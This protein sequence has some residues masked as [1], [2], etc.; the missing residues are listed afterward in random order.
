M[1]KN[2][3]TQTAWSVVTFLRVCLLSV[4]SQAQAGGA[5]SSTSGNS[6]ASKTAS[7]PSSAAA[8]SATANA[9][10]NLYGAGGQNGAQPTQDSFKGSIVSG[11]ATDGVLELS[12]NEA[13]QRGLQQNLGLILQTATQKSS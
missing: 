11:K 3:I 13:I 5:T 7:G 9:Q 2:K 12:L 8:S 10:Q 6:G 1:G 4:P